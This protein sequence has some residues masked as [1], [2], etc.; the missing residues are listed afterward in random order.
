[1]KTNTYDGAIC[2]SRGNYGILFPDFMGCVS[3][4]DTLEKVI[5]MGHEAL[6]LHIEGMSEDNENIPAPRRYTLAEVVALLDDDPADPLNENW[7]TIVPITVEIAER[8]DNVVL[9]LPLSLARDIDEVAADRRRF[10][11]EATRREILRVKRAA[12]KIAA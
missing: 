1:M 3:A 6:E 10:I 7:V 11:I 2:G 12:G 8:E 5:A 9:D 4:G